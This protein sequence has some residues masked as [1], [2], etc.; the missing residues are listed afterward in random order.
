MSL[1]K[2]K[3]IWDKISLLQYIQFP[4]R[5]LAPASLILAIL[6]AISPTFIKK[7]TIRITYSFLLMLFLLSNAR[8]FKGQSYLD[9]ADALYYDDA[10]RI[11]NEMSG[12]LPDYIPIQ[13]IEEKKLKELN[14]SQD[15]IWEENIK[16]PKIKGWNLIADRGHEKLVSINVN[17]DTLINLKLANFPGWIAQI[18]NNP[19]DVLENPEIGNIQILV[20]EGEHKLTVQFSEKTP[21]RLIGNSLSIL[22]LFTLLYIFSP[23][24]EKKR[25]NS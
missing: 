4:W 24:K 23:F 16:D 5:F 1:L 14:L 15:F 13:M 3:F 8:F 9:N 10:E 25:K 6:V 17:Q 11:Q 12:I 7:R 20:P 2:T 22:G 19:V 21:A 18:D